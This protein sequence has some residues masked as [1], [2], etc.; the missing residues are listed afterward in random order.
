[1]SKKAVLIFDIP[2][3]CTECPCEYDVMMCKA[4]KRDLDYLTMSEKRSDWCPITEMSTGDL[5]RINMF[6]NRIYN[7]RMN[8]L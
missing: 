4:V 8:R 6:L 5:A 2:E 3:C 1:M 7:E